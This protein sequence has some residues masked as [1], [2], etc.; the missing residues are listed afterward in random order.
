MEPI[1]VPE[2]LDPDRIMT[3]DRE[4]MTAEEHQGRARELDAALHESCAYGQ[5]LW[6]DLNGVR[7]Y[8]MDCLPD[9]P[10]IPGPHRAAAS[11]TGPDDEQGWTNWIAAFGTVT[12]ALAG[13]HGDSG[14][15]LSEARRTAQLRRTATVLRVY[16]EHPELAEQRS[17]PTELAARSTGPAAHSARERVVRTVAAGA[18]ITL[19]VRGLLPR[20]TRAVQS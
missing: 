12:S 15:G 7:K 20:R 18:L 9:D 11:P 2:V 10:R 17:S 13:P 5:Q 1:A 19:A 16:S 4:E 8:L 14:Y 6:N 3:D